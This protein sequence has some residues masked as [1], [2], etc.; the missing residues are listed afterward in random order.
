MIARTKEK[1][2]LILNRHIAISQDGFEALEKCLKNMSPQEVVDEI[3]ESGLKGR[4]GGGFLTGQ[5]WQLVKDNESDKKYIICNG[6]EGD[7]GAFMD[8]ML[9]E[10]YPFRIIEGLIIAGYAVGASEGILYIRAEYPLAV[11]RIREGIEICQRE[12]S[13]WS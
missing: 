6:D 1:E 13:L 10:S 9:L 8:R 3:K 4:G 7:P 2:D 11:K 5:K 12:G